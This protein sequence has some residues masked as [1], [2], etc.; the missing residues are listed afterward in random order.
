M[1]YHNITYDDMSNGTGLRAVL[2]LSGC[3]HHCKHCQNPVTWNPFDGLE[4]DQKA[5]G[6]LF[7]IL[8]GIIFP[9]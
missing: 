8:G 6:E 1:R 7:E 9:V 3:E 4:F 2:W 5:K